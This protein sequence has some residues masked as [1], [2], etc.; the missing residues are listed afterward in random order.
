LSEMCAQSQV[1]ST[2]KNT[3]AY[4]RILLSSHRFKSSMAIKVFTVLQIS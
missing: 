3:K 2:G 4:L 1:R